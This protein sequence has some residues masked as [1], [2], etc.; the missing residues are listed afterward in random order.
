MYFVCIN[1]T[2]GWDFVY[3]IQS[4]YEGGSEARR[5]PVIGL[6]ADNRPASFGAWSEVEVCLVWSHYTSAIER[7]GGAALI[8]PPT[9]YL[10]DDPGLLLDRIDGLLL[11]GGRDVDAVS[12][13]AD[14]HLENDVG[15]LV[16]DRAETALARAALERSVPVLGVCR[17]MQVLNLVAGGTLDQH[18]ADPDRIHR[19]EPGAFVTHA[20]EVEPGSKLREIVGSDETEIRSHHHQGLAEIGAGLRVSARS[21][22]GVVEAFEGC[23][24]GYCLAVLWHPEEDLEGGGL[25]IYESLIRAASERKER[26]SA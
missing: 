25:A 13:G 10:A 9:A 26:V 14:A 4:M 19:A 21:R 5:R 12:Y 6:V 20:V 16:R 7:A 23:D 24:G 11:T 18:L 15:D 17:G 8:A 1:G 2:I 3:I 22:D